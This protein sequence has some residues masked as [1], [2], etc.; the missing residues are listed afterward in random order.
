M[1]RSRF[2]EEQIISSLL[3]I[4]IMIRRRPNRGRHSFREPLI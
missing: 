4:K 3:I 1:R 2:T